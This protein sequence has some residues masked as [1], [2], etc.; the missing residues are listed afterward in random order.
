MTVGIIQA[1]ADPILTLLRAAP[2]LPPYELLTVYDGEVPDPPTGP[3]DLY[4]LVYMTLTTPMGT[5]LTNASDRG[6]MQ[7]ITHSVSGNAQVNGSAASARIVAQRVRGALLDVVPVISG[8]TSFPIRQT[9]S[10]PVRRD[11][12]AG[13]RVY[14]Q[15]DVWRLETVPG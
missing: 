3:A 5:A 12:T 11:E 15:I 1:H 7:I 9:D 2:P 13:P 4:C 6:I 8:R 10:P 14:D